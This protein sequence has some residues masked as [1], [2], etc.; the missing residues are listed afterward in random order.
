[1]GW[2]DLECK[3]FKRRVKRELRKWKREGGD[4]TR[5]KELKR[6]YGKLCEGKEKEENDRWIEIAKGARTEVKVWEVVNRERKKKKGIEEGIQTEEWVEY[7]KNMLGV[8]GRVR[9]GIRRGGKDDGELDI[10]REE[11]KRA[12]GKLKNGK[13]VGTDEVPG[14]VWKY[15]G[16]K[17]EDWALKMC[18]KVWRG[19]EWIEEWNEGIIVP[20]KKK[21]EGKKDYRGI[22]LTSTLYKVYAMIIWERLEKE[23]EERK[24]VPQNQA[25]FRRGIG[26]VDN[27]IIIITL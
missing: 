2:W 17:V 12:I 13:A 10:T 20:I 5:Y 9:R 14:E 7:F 25:G 22:T 8:E 6:E 1:M 18:N 3:K 15:G 16:E 4:R 23:I 24:M 26:T 21:E 11:I 19:E 27:I